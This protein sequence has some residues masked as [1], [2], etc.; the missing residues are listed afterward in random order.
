MSFGQH[1]CEVQRHIVLDRL[2]G[3]SLHGK[4]KLGS[5]SISP[6]YSPTCGSP[7]GS[8]AA[9]ISDFASYQNSF[10]LVRFKLGTRT[11][12]DRWTDGRARP[13]MRH[14]TAAYQ[15]TNDYIVR[16]SNVCDVFIGI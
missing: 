16:G 8:S 11:A 3:P 15:V 4:E 1:V 13:I 14:R 2:P 12:R 9:L 10:V 6:A 7:G 5:S